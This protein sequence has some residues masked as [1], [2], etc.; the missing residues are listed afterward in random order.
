MSRDEWIERERLRFAREAAHEAILLS[1]HQRNAEQ[2][3][4]L[5]AFKEALR[6]AQ[7]R[8]NHAKRIASFLR[9][10]LRLRAYRKQREAH[11]EEIASYHGRRRT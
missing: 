4:G 9:E 11:D 3:P 7:R 2:N 5:D 10:L 6:D 1:A 8:H